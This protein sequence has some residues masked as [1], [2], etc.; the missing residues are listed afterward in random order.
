MLGVYIEKHFFFLLFDRVSI[1][2]YSQKDSFWKSLLCKTFQNNFE[3]TDF[4]FLL[5][6]SQFSLVLKSAELS[7]LVRSGIFKSMTQSRHTQHGILCETE[8]I[9]KQWIKHYASL[10]NL[11]TTLTTNPKKTTAD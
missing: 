3:S 9:H 2:F 8:V 11:F 7:T 10:N 4:F 6:F 5:H 1:Y